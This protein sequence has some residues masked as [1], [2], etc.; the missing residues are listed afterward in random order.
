MGQQNNHITEQN[1]YIIDHNNT[2]AYQP[3]IESSNI[4]NDNNRYIFWIDDN[5]NDKKKKKK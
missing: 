2:I 1:N 4:E 5:V 3:N